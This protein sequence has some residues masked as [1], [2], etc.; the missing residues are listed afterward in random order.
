MAK[1]VA[2][3]DFTVG[4]ICALPIELAAA[5]EMMDEEYGDLPCQPTDTN[6]YCFGRVGVHNVVAAC[7]PAGQ[8]GSASAA[9]VAAQMKTSFPFLR[10]GVLVGIG[11]GVPNL[12]AGIDI[13]L[14]DVVISQPSGQYGGVIQYD[15]GKTGTHGHITRTGSLNAPSPVLLSGLSKLH[16]LYV[17]KKTQVSEH[18]S[19]VTS[20][21]N[22]RSPGPS[23]DTLYK[24]SSVH[25]GGDSCKKCRKRDVV[26]RE[27]RETQEPKLFL[28]NIASGNQV[29]KDGTTRDA[30]SKE[31]G[32]VFCFEMEAAGLMN[33]FSCIIVRGISDYADAHKNKHWQSY[34]AVTAAAYAK[35]LLRLIPPL[36]DVPEHRE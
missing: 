15:F 20:L 5:T 14:G 28:G 7:L 3:H 2:A 17:R 24:P 18:L 23:H 1:V 32:G 4:W 34:A 22:F 29:M 16:Q 26:K 11:G 31:L 30:Y 19:S 25:V 35:E 12:D 6:I 8:M 21:P 27:E 36:L 33:N 13:R 9:T 10:F